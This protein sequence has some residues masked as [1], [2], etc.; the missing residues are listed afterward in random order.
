VKLDKACGNRIGFSDK[1]PTCMLAVEGHWS[2]HSLA[3]LFLRIE[4]PYA[5]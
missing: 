5:A 4:R 3:T 2:P 1:A